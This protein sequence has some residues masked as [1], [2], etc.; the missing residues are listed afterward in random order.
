MSVLFAARHKYR[1]RRRIM[2]T[3]LLELLLPGLNALF[4]FEYVKYEKE[5]EALFEAKKNDL[6]PRRL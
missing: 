1:S 5:H 2:R 3:R 4:G 6:L